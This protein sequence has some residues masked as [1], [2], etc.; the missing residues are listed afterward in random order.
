MAELETNESASP[1]SASSP[2]PVFE[3]YFGTAEK[4][5]A[6]SSYVPQSLLRPYN[7]DDLWQKTGD[8]RLYEEMANDDQ[9]SVASQLKRDLI[10]GSGWN[11]VSEESGDQEIAKDIYQ[12]LEE[13]VEI[14]FDDQLED[15]LSN[16]YDYGFAC[17]EKIFKM[18]DDNTLSF[19][20]LKTR[21]PNTW[22]LHTDKHGKVI[23][24]EQRGNSED[25]A[26]NPKSL[27]HYINNRKWQNPYGRSDFRAAY[28]AW[29][30]KRHIVRYYSIFLE[31]YA[32][33]VP[34]A[35]Y[36]ANVNKEKVREMFEII[37]KFQQKTAMV[38]P[39]NFEVEFLK[40][41]N[42]GD[43]FI[44]GIDMFNM[45]IGRAM[46]IPDLLGF[47]GA[48]SGQT[49]SQALGKTQMNVFFKHILRRRRS[50]ERMV[51]RHIVQPLV[52][53]NYGFVE[54][55]PK[56]VL[57]PISEDEA[58][59]YA[60]IFLQ[61]VQGKAYVPS[62]EE[63][64]HF[65]SLIKFPE[66]DVERVEAPQ[67]FGPDGQPLD[68]KMGTENED[69]I[70]G[71]EDEEISEQEI[72]DKDLKTDEKSGQKKK[73]FKAFVQTDGSY[74]KK[75]NFKALGSLLESGASKLVADCQ[76]LVAEILSDYEDQIRKK[77]IISDNG[78]HPERIESLKLKRL[79]SLQSV[80]KK[81]LRELYRDSRVL[82]RAELPK[83]NYAEPLPSDKFMQFTEEETYQYVGDWEYN[84]TRQA[85]TELMNAI[86]D[87]KPISSVIDMIDEDS[88]K[89]SQVSL[90]RYA[91]TKFTEVM[92]RARLEE[93][94]ESG[95]VQGYQYSAILDGQT[96]EI[97]AGLHGKKF[98]AGTEP[99]PP[100]HFNCRSVLIPITI[101]E[102]FTPD[103]KVGKTPIDKFIDKNKGKG[104][105]IR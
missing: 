44:K 49:G 71:K 89:L 67:Q 46:L 64:N 6:E 62:D 33:P 88:K 76:P 56:F 87:G 100:M 21:H 1:L 102:E 35:R 17:A 37:R 98:A 38:I 9:C 104:F 5:I 11:I 10:I 103:E 91:R 95:V 13:D 90:E 4:T 31:K 15:L 41:D 81:H 77:K 43:A 72:D 27:V 25:L 12:R 48:R 66:G 45:F 99:I 73:N 22:L 83:K 82:A 59:E 105:A 92:N 32:S 65:R 63:I 53:W 34:V 74:H 79:S 69:E 78:G 29:F 60:K 7:S 16:A 93:F 75:V 57:N 61:A 54:N 70:E 8:Y 18:R 50:L 3:H 19:D 51:N 55:F 40:S 39:K 80:L 68:P 14:A 86:R 97:C 24:Y 47:S 42:T 23:K 84:I 26:I 20:E 36:E 30:V 52:I 58:T 2:N 96:T 85:R 28:D 101:F 94:G